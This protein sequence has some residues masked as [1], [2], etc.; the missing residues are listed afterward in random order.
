MLGWYKNAMLGWYKK[1]RRQE[2]DAFAKMMQ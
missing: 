2:M 1:Y